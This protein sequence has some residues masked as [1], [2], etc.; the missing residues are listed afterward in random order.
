MWP[1]SV[2]PKLVEAMYLMLDVK[3]CWKNIVAVSPFWGNLCR[4]Q[5]VP[6]DIGD[7]CATKRNDFDSGEAVPC[8]IYLWAG[9]LPVD[10]I[11]CV[12]DGAINPIVAVLKFES[13]Q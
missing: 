11:I 9:R 13:V 12:P 6:A 7:L 4:L 1:V 2:H 10:S 3:I 5:W 8:S